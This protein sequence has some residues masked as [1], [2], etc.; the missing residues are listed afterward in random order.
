MDTIVCFPAVLI[1]LYIVDCGA[2]Q[3]CNM[4]NGGQCTE[5][6][7]CSVWLTRLIVQ[8]G[9]NVHLFLHLPTHSPQKTH[10]KELHKSNCL[11]LD[12]SGGRHWYSWSAGGHP[13]QCRSLGWR[14]LEEKLDEELWSHLQAYP[15]TNKPHGS[16]CLHRPRKEDDSPE[17]YSI[18]L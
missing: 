3:V 1:C 2:G 12:D 10:L 7:Q 9:N 17:K 13:Q 18:L 4:Q 16:G 14:P 5:H 15:P 11:A 8:S 6:R